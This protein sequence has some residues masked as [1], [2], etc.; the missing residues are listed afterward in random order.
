VYFVGADG[1]LGNRVIARACA[2]GLI[3]GP[4]FNVFGFDGGVGD[5]R[6][7]GIGN[8]TGDAATVPLGECGQ[9]KKEQTTGDD[10]KAHKLP[11]VF[12][13]GPRLKRLPSSGEYTSP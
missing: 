6:S 12:V 11:P 8:R 2:L 5:Q 13:V 3:D 7:R 1:Q 4:F 10:K 9:G